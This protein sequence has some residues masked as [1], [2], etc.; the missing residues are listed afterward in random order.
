MEFSIW[1]FGDDLAGYLPSTDIY[2]V[3]DLDD[4]IEELRRCTYRGRRFGEQE[5]AEKME[6]EF[7]GV[8]RD[9][10]SRKSAEM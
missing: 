3:S 6:Q 10:E 1:S 8:R 4:R 9:G 5:S 2:G 7:G